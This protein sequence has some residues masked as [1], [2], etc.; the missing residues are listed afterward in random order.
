MLRDMADS[1]KRQIGRQITKARLAC[2]FTQERVAELT[3]RSVEAISNLERGKS[4]P[5]ADTLQSLSA[6]LAVPIAEFF[7]DSATRL[8]RRGRL[9]LK[10]R[11]ILHSLSDE[12]LLIAVEQI[13]VLAK[14]RAR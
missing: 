11:G 7:R 14:R 5:S 6:H 13:T 3:G 2:G 12:F 10:A 8:D 9:E 1:L 4:F